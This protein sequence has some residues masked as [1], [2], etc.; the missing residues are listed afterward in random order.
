MT[1]AEWRVCADLEPM[2][3]YLYQSKASERKL[4]LFACGCC[5]RVLHLLPNELCWKAID[6]AERFADG[7]AA[8]SE[9][10]EVED[11]VN[12]YWLNHEKSEEFATSAELLACQAVGIAVNCDNPVAHFAAGYALDAATAK[13]CNI[14]ESE[15]AIQCEL[16]R[17]VFGN[18]FRLLVLEATW[19]TPPVVNLAQ[20]V[21]DDR[22][23]DRIPELAESL[24]EAGGTDADLLEHLRGPGPHFRGCWA[25]DVVLGKS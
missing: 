23:F 12:A 16:L 17:D 4:R 6:L 1:E 11:A 10:Y 21:Y 24:E 19:R 7:L 3:A 25:L 5:R 2:L 9:M 13:R 15:S 20:S 14:R 8:D 18:P 22:T